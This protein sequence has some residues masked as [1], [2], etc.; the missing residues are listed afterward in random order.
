MQIIER[1][2]LVDPNESGDY[3]YIPLAFYDTEGESATWDAFQYTSDYD[4]T[5]V[6]NTFDATNGEVQLNSS[7]WILTMGT[8]PEAYIYALRIP[9]ST[10]FT[11]YIWV[12]IKLESSGTIVAMVTLNIRKM[13]S[14]GSGGGSGSGSSSSSSSISVPTAPEIAEAV[15]NYGAEAGDDTITDRTLSTTVEVNLAAIAQAVWNYSV[16]EPASGTLGT[17]TLTT[18]IPT[19]ANIATAVLTTDVSDESV[20]TDEYTLKHLV[21]ASQRSKVVTEN[22]ETV[23][24]IMGNRL[25]GETGEEIVIATRT[26]TLNAN[27]AI[28]QTM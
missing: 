23:W 12:N 5:I 24:K 3:W 10:T 7:G 20:E 28:T 2:V 15:W 6:A 1:D 22:G 8:D 11:Q 19:A 25:S 27:G 26:L 17:R 16:A 9:K 13:A 18:A 4:V 21:M 14:G